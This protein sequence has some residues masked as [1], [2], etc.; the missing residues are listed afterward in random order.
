VL[1]L[2]LQVSLIHAALI[3]QDAGVKIVIA[4]LVEVRCVHRF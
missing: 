3:L 4:A 1:T 2:R